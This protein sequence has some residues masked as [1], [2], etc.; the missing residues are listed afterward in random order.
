M[1]STL[2]Q[3]RPY[4]RYMRYP[5]IFAKLQELCPSPQR[6][7]SFGCAQ[8]E[9]ILSLQDVYPNAEV[10]GYDLVKRT[11]ED[12]KFRILDS[13]DDFKHY[14]IICALS[15]LYG[16]SVTWSTYAEIV[17]K[18]DQHLKYNGFLVLFNAQYCFNE[19]PCAH[20]YL[21][22]T[23]PSRERPVPIFRSNGQPA[24]YPYILFKKI[25]HS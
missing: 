3:K 15:V 7:L 14:N 5:L 1:T 23:C 24:I 11:P 20:K 17:T 9:E 4:S 8:G 18:L 21:K 6:I 2:C 16:P 12:A 22:I 13:P 19:L 25:R 10:Y